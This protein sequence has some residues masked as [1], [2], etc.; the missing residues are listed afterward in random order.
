MCDGYVQTQDENWYANCTCCGLEIGAIYL[1][2]TA[3]GFYGS[4]IN[5]SINVTWIERT[6]A[7]NQLLSLV[8]N[9]LMGPVVN[10]RYKC[11]IGWK[12]R[13]RLRM[14]GRW[15]TCPQIKCTIL[16]VMTMG[17]CNRSA[18][19]RKQPPGR[20]FTASGQHDCWLS[21]EMHVLGCAV[22]SHVDSFKFRVHLGVCLL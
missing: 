3:A 20:D 21:Y 10:Y 15:F 11:L 17:W 1:L 13:N 7:L 22:S 12:D 6:E 2:I 4:E 18:L 9:V 5:T 14:Q 19:V 8:D 16:E